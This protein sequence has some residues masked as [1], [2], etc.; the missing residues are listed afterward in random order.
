MR[1]T[2]PD[3]EGAPKAGND[4]D[5]A[6]VNGGGAAGTLGAFAGIAS[7]ALPKQTLAAEASAALRDRLLGEVSSLAFADEATAWAQRASEPRTP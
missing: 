5:R 2:S 1:R 7:H 4:F 6:K 3:R